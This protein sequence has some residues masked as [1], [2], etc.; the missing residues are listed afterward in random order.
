MC[1]YFGWLIFITTVLFFFPFRGEECLK[2]FCIGRAAFLV[3]FFVFFLFHIRNYCSCISNLR[4]HTKILKMAFKY[5]MS[6]LAV[7]SILKAQPVRRLISFVPVAYPW[8][9]AAQLKLRSLQ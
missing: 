5:L 7:Q 4:K 3:F 2:T 9:E 8:A 6:A 1:Q